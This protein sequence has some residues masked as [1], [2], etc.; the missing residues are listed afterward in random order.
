ME[1]AVR[2]QDVYK[3]TEIW[4]CFLNKADDRKRILIGELVDNAHSLMDRCY[5]TFPT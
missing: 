2:M 4:K 5:E 3:T 1:T